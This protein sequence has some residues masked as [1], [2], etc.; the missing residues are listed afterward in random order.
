MFLELDIRFRSLFSAAISQCLGA[1]RL[2]NCFAGTALQIISPFRGCP[3][4][5]SGG[6]VNGRYCLWAIAQ[7]DLLPNAHLG[8]WHSVSSVTMV[9]IVWFISCGQ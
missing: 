5:T 3:H 9:N 8:S 6:C 4:R 1:G 2:G 7:L